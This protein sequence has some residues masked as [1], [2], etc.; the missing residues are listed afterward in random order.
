MKIESKTAGRWSVTCAGPVPSSRRA[1]RWRRWK[2]PRPSTAMRRWRTSSGAW[3][4]GRDAVGVDIGAIR[5]IGTYR[6]LLLGLV[7][8]FLL[9]L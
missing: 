9:L 8:L 4:R 7:L 5:D 6:N 2:P 3:P 1:A